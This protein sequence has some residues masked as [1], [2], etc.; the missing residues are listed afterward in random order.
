MSFR[1]EEWIASI[2]AGFGSI[3]FV[4]AITNEF[5]RMVQYVAPTGGPTEVI[6]L[7]LLLWIHAKYLRHVKATKLHTETV[8]A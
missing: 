4:S 7:A 1:R 8:R 5:P 6:C 3:W 2:A